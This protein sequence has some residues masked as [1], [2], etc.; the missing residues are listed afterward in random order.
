MLL[1]RT[2]MSGT[3][4]DTPRNISRKSIPGHGSYFYCTEQQKYYQHVVNHSFSADDNSPLFK[5]IVHAIYT[6]QED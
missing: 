5:G 1:I 3:A 4:I 6:I 2:D